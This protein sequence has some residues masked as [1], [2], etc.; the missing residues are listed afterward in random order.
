MGY[1]IM[2][3]DK[4]RLLK[5]RCT[6]LCFGYLTTVHMLGTRS[7][8][9]K[10]VHKLFSGYHSQPQAKGESGLWEGWYREY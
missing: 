6:V 2:T 8:V 9:L 5:W 7:L 1:E 10:R 4:V 3:L